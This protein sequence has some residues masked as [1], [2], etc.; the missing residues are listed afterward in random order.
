MTC[1]LGDGCD[2]WPGYP[3]GYSDPPWDGTEA[4]FRDVVLPAR[5]GALAESYTAHLAEHGFG[6]M[7]FGW[8]PA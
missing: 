7:R 5:S 1:P 6:E 8:G 4:G 3:D 2:G